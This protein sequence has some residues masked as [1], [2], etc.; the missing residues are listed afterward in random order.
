[1]LHS[2]SC[3]QGAV[4][5]LVMRPVESSCAPLEAFRKL[6]VPLMTCFYSALRKLNVANNSLTGGFEDGLAD[7][8]HNTWPAVLKENQSMRDWVRAPQKLVIGLHL[9]LYKGCIKSG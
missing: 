1:M 6:Y 7:P 4:P 3:T 5:Q 2:K 8:F 9:K